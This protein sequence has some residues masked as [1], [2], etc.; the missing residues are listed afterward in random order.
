MTNDKLDFLVKNKVI[1]EYYHDQCGY[2]GDAESLQITFNDDTVLTIL[3][4]NGND[5]SWLD[6]G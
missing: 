4:A 3:S 1:K 2:N 5:C 6:I